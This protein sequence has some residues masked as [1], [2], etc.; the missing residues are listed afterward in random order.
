MVRWAKAALSALGEQSMSAFA[1][2][3][4]GDGRDRPATCPGWHAVSERIKV[5]CRAR[6]RLQVVCPHLQ[7]IH[8]NAAFREAD[9]AQL[10][11]IASTYPN[12]ERL[13]TELTLDPPTSIA[14]TSR[15]ERAEPSG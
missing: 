2:E 5:A 7:R 14:G 1:G 15:L 12:R 11:Q 6:S 4:T 9:L 3:R 8:K 13:L 10:A